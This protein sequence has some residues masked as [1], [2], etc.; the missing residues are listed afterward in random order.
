MTH[1]ALALPWLVGADPLGLLG[2]VSASH[3]TRDGALGLVTAVAGLLTAWRPRYALAAALVSATALT[4]QIATA[5][6]D[7]HYRR[8]SFLAE[9]VHGLTVIVTV[10]V[11]WLSRPLA[12]ITSPGTRPSLRA[13]P[14]PEDG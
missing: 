8:V 5:L 11:A 13:V 10:L 4:A 3:L 2:N 14:R 12:P 6:I 1:L 7:E 9:G